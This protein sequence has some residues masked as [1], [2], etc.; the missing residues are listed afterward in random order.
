MGTKT[1]SGPKDRSLKSSTKETLTEEQETRKKDITSNEKCENNEE[2][3]EK[4]R[5]NETTEKE[6]ADNRI[7][8]TE[9][10][11]VERILAAAESPAE[12]TSKAEAAAAEAASEKAASEKAA[13][14][15]AAAVEATSAESAAAEARAAEA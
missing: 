15:K 10:K 6:A 9:A 4:V 8:K 12:E 7:D 2:L 5:A 3:I 1:I 13:A 14:E 11:E